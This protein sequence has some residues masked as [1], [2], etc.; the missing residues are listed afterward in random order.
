MRMSGCAFVVVM[1]ARE[2]RWRELVG[3]KIYRQRQE[4]AYRVRRDAFSR[5]SRAVPTRLHF[6]QA[7]AFTAC[8][9]YSLELSYI[10]EG[11]LMLV[12]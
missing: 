3:Y 10:L 5:V 1:L 8:L 4:T 6:F 7:L 12:P 2:K 9:P 11:K